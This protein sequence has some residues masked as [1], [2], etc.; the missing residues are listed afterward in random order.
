[1]QAFLLYVL[2]IAPVLAVIGTVVAATATGIVVAVR[3]YRRAAV[4]P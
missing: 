4:K 1:M 3:Q 2:G